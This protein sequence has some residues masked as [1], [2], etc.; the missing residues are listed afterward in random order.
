MRMGV[1]DAAIKRCLLIGRSTNEETE[2]VVPWCFILPRAHVANEN[3]IIPRARFLERSKAGLQSSS[4]NSDNY[5]V[6]RFDN[7]QP[8]DTVGSH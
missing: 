6:P 5:S 2:H 7:D 3:P 4:T 1:E 8:K